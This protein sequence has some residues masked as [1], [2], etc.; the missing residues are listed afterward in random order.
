MG[1]SL[2]REFALRISRTR[3]ITR[4]SVAPFF[5]ARSEARWIVGPSASGSLKGTPSSMTSAPASAIAKTNF[6][7]AANE[8]SPAVIYATIPISPES[9][10][11]AKR[12]VMR[13]V[14][15]TSA[16]I[17]ECNRLTPRANDSPQNAQFRK[18]VTNGGNEQG[19]EL[20]GFF[21]EGAGVSV[22]ILVATARDIDDDQVFARE[23]RR[24]LDEAGNGMCGFERG[25]DAFGTRQKLCCIKSCSIGDGGIFCPALI[26]Q[27]G[28]L[29]TDRWIVETCGNGMRGGDLPVVRLQDVS[30]GALQNARSRSG[31]PL[32]RSE[33]CRV[34]AQFVAAA[35]SFDAYHLHGL[36]FQEFVEEAHG[37]R[38][39]ANAG[40]KMRGQTLF[41]GKD[42]CAGLAPNAGMK[43]AHHRRIR[44]RTQNRAEEVVRGADVGD[45][46]AHR[47]IDGVFQSTA[48]GL[49][50]DHFRA[51]H[52]H[53]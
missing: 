22:H 44:M 31:E 1:T 32:R 19:P 17:L 16:L 24:A 7:V 53:A 14:R 30:V 21:A 28:V 18:R 35:T 27:P 46:V 9:R 15:C 3:S 2:A 50:A 26:S 52:A 39:A 36:V 13:V 4:A 8:G 41:R 48:A 25:N 20:S 38:A 49:D 33:T 43:I 10:S 29:G 47:L 12:R 40:E 6:S 51:E 34:F 23:L 42:L 45:P 11:S 5:S 37:V